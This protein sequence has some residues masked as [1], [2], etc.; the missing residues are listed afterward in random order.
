[1]MFLDLLVHV[2]LAGVYVTAAW[3]IVDCVTEKYQKWQARRQDRRQTDTYNKFFDQIEEY[4]DDF[5]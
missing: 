4:R 5:S 2:I 3:A 1:M